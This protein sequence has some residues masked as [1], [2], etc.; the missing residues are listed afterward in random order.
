M[1]ETLAGS[2]SHRE[3]VQRRPDQ[4]TARTLVVLSLLPGVAN[5]VAFVVFALVLD[6]AGLPSVLALYLAI[7]LVEAPVAWYVMIRTVR[8]EHRSVT[9]HQL[10]PWRRPVGW[11]QYVVLGIP[12]ALFSVAAIGIGSQVVGAVVRPALFGWIPASLV[13]ELDPAAF[14]AGGRTAALTVWVLALVFGVVVGSV[15]QELYFRGFLLPADGA[16]RSIGGRRKHPPVRRVPPRIAVEL[17]DV[18]ARRRAVGG[19]RVVEAKHGVRTRRSR[20]DATRLV[21]RAVAGVVRCRLT[22]SFSSDDSLRVVVPR[23][24]PL[25]EGVAG[26]VVTVNRREGRWVVVIHPVYHTIRIP[27]Q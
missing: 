13:V 15:T 26:F 16:L 7:G 25:R 14:A 24:T 10:F 12:A 22:D 1:T 4:Y 8:H 19:A 23:P 27:S 2:H 5:V 11:W 6:A 9:R 17:A 3:D 21:V 18:C 20:R